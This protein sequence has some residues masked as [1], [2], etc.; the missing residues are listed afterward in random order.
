MALQTGQTYTL[1]GE[2]PTGIAPGGSE[3]KAPAGSQLKIKDTR[4]VGGQLYY[5]IDQ[6]AFGGGTGW[7]L[8]SALE[9]AIGQVAPALQAPRTQEEV[10]PYLNQYQADLFKAQERPEVKVPTMEELKAELAPTAA[11][12]EPLKRV[13]ESERMMTEYGVADLEKSLA[14]IKDQITAE[15]DLLREQRGIEEGKPVPMGVIAGRISE[16]ERVANVRLDALG[17]QQ[18]RITDE[19]NTKYSLVNT[20]M[21]FMGLDYNDA[22]ARYDTEFKQNIAIYDIMAGE[23]K[24]ARSAYEYD[25]SVAK[26][27]LQIYTNAITSGNLTYADMS[28]DQK[29]M[30]TKL[31]VQSG[32]PIGFIS[33]LNMSAKDRLLSVNDKTGEALMIDANGNFNVVQTGMRP[34]PTAGATPG[35]ETSTREGF[36]QEAKTITGRNIGGTW[37][38]EFPLLVQNYAPMMS[39]EEIYRIYMDSELG[40]KYGSPTEDPAEIKRIYDRARGKEED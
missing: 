39:L 10:T 16:E 33:N 19:L 4:T 20:Y 22:V 13:E 12:P 24:E 3:Y 14:T 7:T 36:L 29:L 6:T 32:L 37:V 2:I 30:V 25:Q 9:G 18:A 23:R 5:D 27:N 17:R 11:Y 26:A 38:G 40:K 21:T 28:S 1:S 34:T 15:Q 31:E 8:A 35:T